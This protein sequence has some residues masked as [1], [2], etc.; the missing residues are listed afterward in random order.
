[1]R[2]SEVQ[3][4]PT[5]PCFSASGNMHR[6]ES[7]QKISKWVLCTVIALDKKAAW[8]GEENHK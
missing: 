4:V 2:T 3:Q 7:S 5:Q 6:L 1:M 8:T